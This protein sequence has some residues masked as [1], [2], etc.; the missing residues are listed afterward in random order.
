VPATLPSAPVLPPV[1][2]PPSPVAATAPPASTAPSPSPSPSPSPTTGSLLVIA[3][4]WAEIVVD[5]MSV[6]QTP[7]ARFPLPTGPH[8]VLLRHPDYVPF[9]RR[10]VIAPGETLVLRVDLA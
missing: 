10:V 3:S 2:A 5:G 9:P 4:P 6:G 1:T 7:K 8:Q